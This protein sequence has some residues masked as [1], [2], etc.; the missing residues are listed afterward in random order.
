MRAIEKRRGFDQNVGMI[1]RRALALSLAVVFLV[2]PLAHVHWGSGG[3]PHCNFCLNHNSVAVEVVE[4]VA[5]LEQ[6]DAEPS[7]QRVHEGRA[8]VPRSHSRAPPC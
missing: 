7:L 4:V 1:V 8:A 2:V 6:H 3:E 5:V